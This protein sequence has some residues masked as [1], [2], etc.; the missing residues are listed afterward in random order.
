MRSVLALVIVWLLL[1]GAALAAPQVKVPGCDLV[2]PWAA[3]VN[4]ESFNVAPRLALPKAFQ[5]ADLVPVFGAPV[6]TWSDEDVKAVSQG[7]VTCYQ[8]AGKRRDQAAI[9]ALANAN[10]ALLGLVPRVN[11]ALQ[12][13]R[14]DAA[15]VKQQIDAL[16]DSA[17]LGR[18]L[19]ALVKGNPTA[20]D[21]NQFR[22]L[23]RE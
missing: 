4:A 9:G 12:K 14:V 2:N 6:T 7:L 21:A 13:A 8:D 16:A 19:E 18:A 17:E 1:A 23:P 5:D 20:P 3:R 15:T 10:R 22:T 11:A